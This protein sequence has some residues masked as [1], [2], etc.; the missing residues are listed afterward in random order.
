MRRMI[1]TAAM[2][3]ALA[4][5]PGLAA[6]Q[7]ELAAQGAALFK[8]LGCAT[9][10]VPDEYDQAPPLPGVVGRK[11]AGAP[12]WPYCSGLAHK[13]GTWDEASLDAYLT[14]AQ[15]FAPGCAMTYKIADPAQR[16]ALIAYLKTLK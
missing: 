10:H 8:Q 16:K 4:A 14:D 2:A 13:G 9:C 1:L 6:A 11:I 12:S 15:T 7:P 3:A 5:G